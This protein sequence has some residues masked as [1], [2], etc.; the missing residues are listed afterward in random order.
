[1]T[2]SKEDV[3]DFLVSRRGKI[4]PDEA[5]LS[6]YGGNRRVP[7]LRREE[8][9]L[10]AGVSVDYYTRL[11]KGNLS[12][13]SDSVLHAIADALRLQD[14]ERS[15]LFD[16][17]RAATVSGGRTRTPPRSRVRLGLQ[18]VLDGMRDMPAF[19][20]NG[21][22]DVLAW[23]AL[24]DA[25]Y[26]GHFSADREA[27]RTPN[28]ARFNVLEPAA[29]TFYGDWGK[30][31]DTTAAM[32]RTEVG[33]SPGDKLLSNLV[34]ELCTRSDD[35][36]R[37]WAHHDVRIHRAGVKH[38]H[39]SQVGELVLHYEVL[40]VLADD[41]QV[42]TVYTAEPNSST[43]HALQLLAS[44]HATPEAQDRETRR[45]MTGPD[46]GVGDPEDEHTF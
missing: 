38:F 22:M 24:G 13:V 25:M 1:M 33:R 5:G 3:R 16:L 42:M 37:R 14:A 34:G 46:G 20:A 27:G 44:L 23:N 31:L 26:S 17:A 36:A 19:V 18:L 43:H 8:V 6:H 30:A 35:F 7:G 10:L 41:G 21:R 32:L 4:A 11:E 2:T 40:P 39:H 28:F 15:H 29:Q 12:G 45:P 9:A